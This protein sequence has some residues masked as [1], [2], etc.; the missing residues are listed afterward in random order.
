MTCGLLQALEEVIPQ[1]AE[2]LSSQANKHNLYTTH[3]SH[4]QA[5]N[6]SA[7]QESTKQR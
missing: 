1:M 3:I 5:I 4:K 2:K 7:T 6:M